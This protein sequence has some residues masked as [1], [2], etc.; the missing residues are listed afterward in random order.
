MNGLN[1]V[2][3]SISVV[4]ETAH[5]LKVFIKN[6]CVMQNFL[7]AVRVTESCK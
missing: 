5:A 7:A 2:S 6:I 4:Y 1:Y 3:K